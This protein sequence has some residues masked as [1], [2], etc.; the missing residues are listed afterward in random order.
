MDPIGLGFEKFDAIGRR[1]EKQTIKFFPDRKAKDQTP[2]TVE[3]DLDYQRESFGLANS[4][5]R[6]PV[7][8]GQILATAGLSGV[9]CEAVFPVR[10][11]P[12]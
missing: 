9:Y 1:R 5:F 2:T 7:E 4:D 10:L 8:L 11:R 3:L 6:T 12:A